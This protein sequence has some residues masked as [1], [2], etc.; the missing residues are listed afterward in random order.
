MTGFINRI[1]I[2]L[3]LIS[4]VA[5][6]SSPRHDRTAEEVTPSGPPP[7]K[8]GT[9]YKNLPCRSDPSVTYAIYFPSSWNGTDR[10]PVFLAFD[11]E[12]SGQ[13]PVT[14]YKDLA[15]R[16]GCILMGSNNSRNGQQIEETARIVGNLLDEIRANLPVDTTRIYLT[17]FSGGSRVASIICMVMPGIRGMIGCGAGFATIR[18]P[19]KL[20][21]EYFGIVG[22]ADFNLQELITLNDHLIEKNVRHELL[23]FKGK[24]QW[25]PA[26]VF[27]MGLQWS[28]KDGV[29]DDTYTADLKKLRDSGMIFNR[30]SFSKEIR[31]KEIARQQEYASAFYAKDISWWK[32]EVAKLRITEGLSPDIASMNQRLLSYLSLLCYSQ[33]S[34][35]LQQRSKENAY[36]SITLY[37]L[38]DPENP[39]VQ[40]MK[41]ELA[42]MP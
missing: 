30:S 27:A 6:S 18:E 38:V 31:D 10:L 32:K 25:P 29:K 24:H 12:A 14:K 13:L 3:F 20:A 16:Y 8:A 35:A 37:D 1:T 22:N 33:S 11:P 26:E 5:C 19:E 17:G 41:G 42:N 2:F 36:Y 23:I 15:D 21:F 28:L 34:R 9:I 7:Y 40:R 39:E 4:F